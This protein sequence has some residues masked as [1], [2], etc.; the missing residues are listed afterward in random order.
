MHFSTIALVSS[1]L[2]LGVSAGPLA[3]RGNDG[4]P[5]ICT[6]LKTADKGCIRYVK[7]FDV[8]GV[9]TEVDLTFPE[10]KSEC[11]CIQECLNRPTTC[12]SWVYKF[13]TPQSVQSGHR[14]CTLYSQFN[15]PAAVTIEIDLDSNKNKNINAQEIKMLGNNPQAGAPVP[16]AFKDV[17]LNTIADDKAFSGAVW[18]LANGQAIC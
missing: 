11:D 15:L 9:V 13:S 16:Q 18:Q 1:I 10:V 12:A 2:A 17:N 7:G 4:L 8:T 5:K 6:N 3:T 14:T